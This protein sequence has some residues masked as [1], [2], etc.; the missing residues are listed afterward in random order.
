MTDEVVESRDVYFPGIQ[1]FQLHSADDY[2]FHLS[3]QVLIH[4][5]GFFADMF[6]MGASN[7]GSQPVTTAER[8]TILNPVLCLAYAGHGVSTPSISSFT[9]LTTLYRVAEK[10]E[11]HAVLQS[12]L[13]ILFHTR[14]VDSHCVIPFVK[15]HPIP[16]LA[17]L[18]LNGNRLGI[19]A[20]MQECILAD[21]KVAASETDA[22]G[23][24]I[25]VQMVC[26]IHSQRQDRIQFIMTRIETWPGCRVNGSVA[27]CLR[28]P[29]H[30]AVRKVVENNPTLVA[31]SKHLYEKQACPSCGQDVTSPCQYNINSLFGEL[32][33]LEDLAIP[34]PSVCDLLTVHNVSIY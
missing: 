18:M 16:S 17:L 1:D 15:T 10:Y 9:T 6:A 34:L 2:T 3:R 30:M 33:N 22:I 25:D 14:T 28:G 4:A 29:W 7:P 31:L 23:V 5:S 19:Q 20:A 21:N 12:L 27:D 32:Q 11:M 24:Q 26:Y 13:S 8:H